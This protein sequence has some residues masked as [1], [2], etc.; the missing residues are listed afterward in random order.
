MPHEQVILG[1]SCPYCPAFM[2]MEHLALTP[3]TKE[4]FRYDLTKILV[5]I[6][7]TQCR[8]VIRIKPH[9]VSLSNQSAPHRNTYYD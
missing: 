8:S 4:M 7:C 2:G 6:R 9:L 5:G 1:L 3:A